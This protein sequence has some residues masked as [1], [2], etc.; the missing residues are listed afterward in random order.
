MVQRLLGID[1][2]AKERGAMAREIAAFLKMSGAR[3][4]A[5][6]PANG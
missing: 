4:W 6:W 2:T 1:F 3:P 5:R